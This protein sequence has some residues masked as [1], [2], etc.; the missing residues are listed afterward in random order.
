M[1]KLKQAY[2]I[3]AIL[4]LASQFASHT[5][6]AAIVAPVIDTKA[7]CEKPAYPRASLMNEE[8]GTVVLAFLIAAD[9]KVLESKVDKSSGFKNLDKAALN[10]L[11]QCKFKPGTKD[12]RPD[13]AWAKVEYTWAL[14]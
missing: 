6:H 8:K 1:I 13:Q 7:N 10:A 11:S 9:G 2:L 14:D 12:G 4:A 3:G 5:A